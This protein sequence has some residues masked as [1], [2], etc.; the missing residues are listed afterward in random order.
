DGDEI[1]LFSAD[2]SGNLT[3]YS[4]GF[5]FGAAAGGVTFGRYVTSTGDEHFVAQIVPTLHASNA[6][7]RVGPVVIKQIM[8][9][10]PDRSRGLD[11]TV[12]EYVEIASIAAE[13][14]PLFDPQ[15]P[16][17][18][19]QLRGG[20]SFDFPTNLTLLPGGSLVLVSFDPADQTALA[21]FRGR[22]GQFAGT[23]VVGP[24]NG[25]L[26]N[27]RDSVELNRPGSPGSNGVPRILVD[28]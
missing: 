15:F 1:Y 6:G 3:G 5:H 10:P 24:Y 16:A 21:V 22:Y 7:P 11:D 19:W 20:I 2:A 25:K 18:T 13:A 17:N 28:E 27:D 26:N 8:Y 23:P 4:H 14:V 12:D 9:H